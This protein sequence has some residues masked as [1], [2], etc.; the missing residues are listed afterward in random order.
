MGAW[1]TLGLAIGG[2]A[3]SI[4]VFYVLRWGWERQYV[5]TVEGIDYYC[6]PAAH[7]FQVGDVYE[8]V[9][10]LL[11]LW[12]PH[13]AAV[14][15]KAALR[16]VV[17]YMKPY[18]YWTHSSPG[19]GMRKVAGLTQDKYVQIAIGYESIKRTAHR[20][21]LSHVILNAHTHRRIPEGEAHEFFAEIGI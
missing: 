4:V 19:W 1:I 16:G 7:A 13:V 17:C 10:R 3:A 11:M 20:H 8:D 12:A 14:E 18:K 2:A 5:Y 15:A 21:E 9:M 6:H